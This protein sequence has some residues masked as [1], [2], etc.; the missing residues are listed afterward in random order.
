MPEASRDGYTGTSRIIRAA[1]ETLYRAFTDPATLLVW[2]PP[3]QVTCQMHALDARVGGYRMSLYYPESERRYRGK[4]REREDCVN[5]RFMELSPP[6]RIV[7]AV[8]FDSRD[9]AF[10]PKTMKQAAARHWTNSRAMRS[11]IATLRESGKDYA[12]VVREFSLAASH[13]AKPPAISLTEEN[14]RPCRRLAAIDE[15]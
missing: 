10:G 12:G 4:T 9:A 7:E 1:R 13:A 8:A 3:E 15:R 6:S 11:T 5:V 14:P 2:L